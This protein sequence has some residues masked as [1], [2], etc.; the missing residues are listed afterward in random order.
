MPRKASSKTSSPIITTIPITQARTNLSALVTK[1]HLNREY[2]IL[3]RNGIPIAG[4]MDIDE[5][6]DY[7][8]LQD[9]KIRAHI[10]KSQQEYRAGKSRPAEEFLA[11]LRAEGEGKSTARRQKKS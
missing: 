10:R 1:V 7:L 8:E 4:I 5:F 6:E 3:E 2:V 11:E 9:P